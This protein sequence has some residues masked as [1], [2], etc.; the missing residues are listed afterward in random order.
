M[1]TAR[2]SSE[3]RHIPYLRS[4]PASRADN[5]IKNTKV[6]NISSVNVGVAAE[7]STMIPKKLNWVVVLKL[8]TS[9]KIGSRWKTI[10]RGTKCWRERCS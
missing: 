6:A 2:H 3:N 1:R 9:S 5:G 10:V 8:Q 7:F 4:T